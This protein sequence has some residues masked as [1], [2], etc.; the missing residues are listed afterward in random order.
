MFKK[1]NHKILFVCVLF[2][3]IPLA[4]VACDE[5]DQKPNASTVQYT[6][7]QLLA[8]QQTT[9]TANQ[10]APPLSYSQE[11]AQ[12]IRKAELFSDKNKIGYIYLISYGRVMAFYPIKGK[13]SSLQTYLTTQETT[14]G[15]STAGWTTVPAPDIDG[16]YGENAESI[17]FFTPEGAYIEWKGEYM[18]SDTP[19]KLNTQPDIVYIAPLVE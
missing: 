9:L 18:Y 5:F 2:F 16:T 19:L 11:R 6:S 3:V 13:V 7:Q 8:A 17:F 14:Y 12:Q 15:N 10:P 1:I 4:L